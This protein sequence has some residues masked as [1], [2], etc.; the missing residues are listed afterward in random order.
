MQKEL[1]SLKE[2]QHEAIDSHHGEIHEEGEGHDH[3]SEKG[4]LFILTETS[5]LLHFQ[6]KLFLFFLNRIQE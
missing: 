6:T 3:G 5:V 1:H 4:L 2:M